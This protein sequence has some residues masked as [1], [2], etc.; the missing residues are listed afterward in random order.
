MG[1]FKISRL[2]TN[3][4]PGTSSFPFGTVGVVDVSVLLSCCDGKGDWAVVAVFVPAD[5]LD[6]GDAA[7]DVVVGWL[8]VVVAVGVESGAGEGGASETIVWGAAF[9]GLTGLI[10]DTGLVG[11]VGLLRLLTQL[12]ALSIHEPGTG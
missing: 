11:F 12:F 1:L 6:A 3:P 4:N 5:V 7:A 8:S 10:G 9:N 2:I